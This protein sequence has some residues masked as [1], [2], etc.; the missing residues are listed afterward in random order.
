LNRS[1]E[2]HTC[3]LN[4]GTHENFPSIFVEENRYYLIRLP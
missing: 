4:P 1:V 3:N 2:M